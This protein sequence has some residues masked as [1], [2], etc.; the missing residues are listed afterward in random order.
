MMKVLETCDQGN[1]DMPSSLDADN[2]FTC[3]IIKILPVNFHDNQDEGEE[4]HILQ[5]F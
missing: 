5:Q 2:I 1:L 4:K 3:V